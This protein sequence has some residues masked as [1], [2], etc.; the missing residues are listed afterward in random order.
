MSRRRRNRK[1][2]LICRKDLKRSQYAFHF[3]SKKHYDQH[4]YLTYIEEWLDGKKPGGGKR[5]V[6]KHV[7]RW[8]YAHRGRKCEHCGWAE[9]NP[10]SGHIPVEINHINGD[11]GDH[12]P[13]NLE[14]L[15]PNCHSLTPTY[16]ALNRKDSNDSSEDEAVA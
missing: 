5:R 9:K 11:N 2:C 14:L 16:G 6:S 7:R 13:E 15:C 3:C 10:H 4:T 1:H 8:L 12:R